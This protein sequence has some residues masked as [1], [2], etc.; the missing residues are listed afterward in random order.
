MTAPAATVPYAG[1]PCKCAH[2]GRQYDALPVNEWGFHEGCLDCGNDVDIPQGPTD[3]PAPSP[4]EASAEPLATDKP[5][6]GA[7]TG[8]GVDSIHALACAM[9][10]VRVSPARRRA[11]GGAK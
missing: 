1:D 9:V 11:I 5:G 8:A 4:V 6:T 7:A 2:C 10:G 3:Y